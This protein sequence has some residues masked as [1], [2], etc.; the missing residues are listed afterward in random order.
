MHIYIGRLIDI[1]MNNYTDGHIDIKK[2]FV[3]RKI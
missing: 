1:L 3:D 2:G